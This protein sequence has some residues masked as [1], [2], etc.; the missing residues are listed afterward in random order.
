LWDD[1]GPDQLD[2]WVNRTR[3]LT[4]IETQLKYT[5]RVMRKVHYR[6]NIL[7]EFPIYCATIIRAVTQYIPHIRHVG[8]VSAKGRNK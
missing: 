2:N 8:L 5:V 1:N 7:L 4:D 6:R 3:C